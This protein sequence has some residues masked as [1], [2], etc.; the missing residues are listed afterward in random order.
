[1]NTITEEL[2]TIDISGETIEC[3]VWGHHYPECKGFHREEPGEPESYELTHLYTSGLNGQIEI[4]QMLELDF[5]RD[6]IVKQ[7]KEN[8]SE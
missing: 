3:F 2:V 7:L 5:V 4:S 8:T 1:M 6:D